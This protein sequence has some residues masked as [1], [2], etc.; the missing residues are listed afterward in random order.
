VGTVFVAFAAANAE[1][2]VLPLF[3]PSDRPTFKQLTGQAAFE[4][5]RKKLMKGRGD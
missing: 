2:T 3:F 5:L 4:M 1:T